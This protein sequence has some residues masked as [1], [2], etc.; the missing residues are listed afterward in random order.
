[1]DINSF[2]SWETLATF[3]GVAACTGLFTQMLKSMTAE[4][5][6]AVAVL[7]H[8]GGATGRHNSSHRRLDAA[9]DGLGAD[10]AE[11]SSC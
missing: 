5:T 4:A 2:L 3:T 8:C 9:L 1:M 6:D 10:T 11:C 7:H